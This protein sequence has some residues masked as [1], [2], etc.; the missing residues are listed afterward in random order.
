MIKV[1]LLISERPHS[2][3]VLIKCPTKFMA[4]ERNFEARI[5]AIREKELA[6]QRI[7]FLMKVAS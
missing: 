5:C 4:W 6:R 2:F 3:I 1:R 7:T